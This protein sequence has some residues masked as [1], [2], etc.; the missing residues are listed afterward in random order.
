VCGQRRGK[1]KLVCVS[2]VLTRELRHTERTHYC[3]WPYGEDPVLLVM[4]IRVS[5]VLISSSGG[6]LTALVTAIKAELSLDQ[7]E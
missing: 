6:L 7:I 3:Q 5:V 4:S 2:L 1:K